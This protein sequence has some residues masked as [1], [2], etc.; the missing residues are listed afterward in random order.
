M[1]RVSLIDTRREYAGRR[2]RASMLYYLS[3]LA[4]IG[5]AGMLLGIGGLPANETDAGFM[6]GMGLLL[7][8]AGI[9]IFI[10]VWSY[11]ISERH[12]QYD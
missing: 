6:Q 12:Y 10:A 8:I 9:I 7:L 4:I 1:P 2:N 11:K 3:I 5:G